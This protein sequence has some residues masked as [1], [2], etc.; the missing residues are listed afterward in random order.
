MSS[1]PISLTLSQ[2]VDREWWPWKTS[3]TRGFV[4][5]G[6]LAAGK[7]GGKVVVREDVARQFIQDSA[8]GELK[9]MPWV[10][11]A[12]RKNPEE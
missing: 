4:Y 12:S 11:G 1:E 5:S 6:R 7:I 3:T 8:S 10:K 2:L 9:K